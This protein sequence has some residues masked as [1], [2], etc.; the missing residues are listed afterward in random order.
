MK[1]APVELRFC[2][3]LQAQVQGVLPLMVRFNQEEDF[4][5]LKNLKNLSKTAQNFRKKSESY[6]SGERRRSGRAAAETAAA[7]DAILFEKCLRL[8]YNYTLSACP[9]AL[10]VSPQ[11]QLRNLFFIISHS[12]IA[13][14]AMHP[15]YVTV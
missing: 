2:A 6:H 4:R 15:C 7:R 1:L 10:V 11:Q 12:P 14:E 13:S 8:V 3:I 5:N 9:V